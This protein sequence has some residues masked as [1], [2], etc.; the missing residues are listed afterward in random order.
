[1][2][3]D[4]SR[5]ESHR[6][7]HAVHGG[8]V[9]PVLFLLVIVAL[10][11]ILGRGFFLR[12]ALTGVVRHATGCELSVGSL[13]VGLLDTDLMA[14]NVVLKSPE[15]FADEPMAVADAV[16]VDYELRPLLHGSFHFTR[17]DLNINRITLVRNREGR[18]NVEVFNTNVRNRGVSRTRGSVSHTAVVVS[19]GGGDAGSGSE[20][21]DFFVEN[22]TLTVGSIVY[23]DYSAGSSPLVTPIPLKFEKLQ[24]HNVRGKDV[25]EAMQVLT[26][27][28]TAGSDAAAVLGG[29]F[30]GMARELQKSF[31]KPGK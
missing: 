28:A 24:L 7:H 17:L 10:V 30:Q 23:K 9:L 22:G 31:R 15:G 12:F 2:N 26:K 29:I 14:R 6:G 1:M 8:V 20:E 18:L 16:F 13:D 4:I 19:G 25:D 11:A 21:E 5:G 3:K 27:T